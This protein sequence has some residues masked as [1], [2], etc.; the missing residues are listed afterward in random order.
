MRGVRWIR[1]MSGTLCVCLLQACGDGLTTDDRGYTK[2]PLEQPGLRIRAEGSSAMDSLGS[3]VV[4][5]D[6]LIPPEVSPA[7]T[8]SRDE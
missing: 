4:A 2:A 7:S 6:T 5:R 8:T 3:P 1:V